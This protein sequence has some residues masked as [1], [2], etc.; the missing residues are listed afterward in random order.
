MSWIFPDQLHRLKNS[1]LNHHRGR[2][3]VTTPARI[4]VIVWRQTIERKCGYIA[5]TLIT[6]AESV[7]IIPQKY[8]KNR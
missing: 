6:A 1:M 4:N 7:S 2:A 3:D 5:E 8:V